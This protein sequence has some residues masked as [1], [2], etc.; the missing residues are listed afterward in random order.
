MKFLFLALAFIVSGCCSSYCPSHEKEFTLGS[1][2]KEVRLGMSQADVIR[3]LGS[4]N[5]ISKDADGK[6]NYVY[7]KISSEVNYSKEGGGLWLLLGA[8]ESSSGTQVSSQKTLTVV[9]KFD[10]KSQVENVSY[11]ATKF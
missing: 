4:P 8:F 10:K 11:H 3:S 9:I 1:V 7:D 2:Q 5:I 6:E